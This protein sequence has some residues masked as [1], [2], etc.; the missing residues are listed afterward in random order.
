[1][2]FWVLSSLL[3]ILFPR[4]IHLPYNFMISFFFLQLEWKNEEKDLT[5]MDEEVNTEEEE[6]D[7]QVV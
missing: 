2:P 4:S 1:M 6:R 5:W 7:K 3:K